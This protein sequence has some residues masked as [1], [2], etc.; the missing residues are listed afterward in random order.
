MFSRQASGEKPGLRRD[1]D[2]ASMSEPLVLKSTL[3][4]HKADLPM[5][6][7]MTQNEHKQLD[8]WREANLYQRI[9][10]AR[11]GKPLFVLHDGPPYPSSTIHLGTGLNQILKDLVVNTKSMAG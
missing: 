7:G 6:A 8:A 5:T 4:L 9:L 10:G 2:A 1:C 11:Q 3:N